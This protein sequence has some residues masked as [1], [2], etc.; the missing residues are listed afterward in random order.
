MSSTSTCRTSLSPAYVLAGEV[1]AGVW[2]MTKSPIPI[3]LAGL[4]TSELV[5]PDAK[6]VLERFSR[7]IIV[8]RS[9]RPEL[10][11]VLD[12]LQLSALVNNQD[13]ADAEDAAIEQKIL[14]S[15]HIRP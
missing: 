9:G 1:D 2:R 13:R 4:A 5:H 11:A 3:R 14:A 15:A 7:A 12:A 10:R 6:Q 8:G